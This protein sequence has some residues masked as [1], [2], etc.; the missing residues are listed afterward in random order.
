MADKTAGGKVAGNSGQRQ[1]VSV[2]SEVP[3]VAEAQA[4]LTARAEANEV[5]AA[6]AQRERRLHLQLSYGQAMMWVKGHAASETKAA[7]H[8][9]RTFVEQAEAL[10]ERIEDP[11]ALFSILY[12]FW[13]ANLI[14][15][16]GEPVSNLAT[17]FLTLAEKHKAT[18]PI[19]IGHRLVGVS[20]LHEGDIERAREHFD[21]AIALYDRASHRPFATRFMMD[22]G[23]QLNAWRALALWL[24]GYPDLAGAAA[25][26]AIEDARE[27]GH[28]PTLMSALSTTSW[29]RFF[30]G[31][32][33]KAIAH[34]DELLGLAEETGSS[35]WKSIGMLFRGTAFTAAGASDAVQQLTSALPLYRSTGAAL[36]ISYF[37]SV[38]GKANAGLGQIDE[39]WRCVD[40][41]VGAMEAT[42]ERWYEAEIHRMAGEIALMSSVPDAA[43]AQAHFER[44]L[45]IARA[46]LLRSW[47]LRAATSLARLWRDHGR[48]AEAHD[49]LAPVYGWF[50][51]G[52]DTPDL[53]EA[54]ALLD[55]LAS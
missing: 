42:G 15:F 4:L 12:G 32:Y 7:F 30:A 41:A 54:K 28:V 36:S 37:L 25:D 9:A 34:A 35:L 3:E 10:G 52:F 55:E 51:E 18:V 24:L 19:A 47:E 14:A 31:S 5:K 11:L 27:L 8:R 6:I 16:R 44:A 40:E 46:Q 2:A 17:Q 23:V 33:A 13:A 45:E 38:L 29:T 50:T 22:I 26:R 20:L 49:L 48:R 43:K 53:R 39:A 1:Q 21:R